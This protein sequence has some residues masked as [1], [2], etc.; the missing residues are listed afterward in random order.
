[1]WPLKYP[2]YKWEDYVPALPTK[3]QL[4]GE[5]G[6]TLASHAVSLMHAEYSFMSVCGVYTL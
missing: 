3:N 2:E 4:P 1:M 5:T 6:N